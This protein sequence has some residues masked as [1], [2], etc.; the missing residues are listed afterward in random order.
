[1]NSMLHPYGIIIDKLKQSMFCYQN[2]QSI[3]MS[4]VGV[5]HISQPHQQW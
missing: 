4:D 2:W 1:M 3:D 5:Q